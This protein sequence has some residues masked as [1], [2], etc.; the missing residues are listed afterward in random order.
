MNKTKFKNCC[1]YISIFILLGIMAVYY[2]NIRINKHY[3]VYI[4]EFLDNP[5]N[6][7]DETCVRSLINT[8]IISINSRLSSLENLTGKQSLRI[9]QNTLLSVNAANKVNKLQKLIDKTEKELEKELKN[10]EN[11]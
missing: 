9:K 11:F 1:L 10:N 7:C 6:V 8:P 5:G 2:R 3:P 4:R